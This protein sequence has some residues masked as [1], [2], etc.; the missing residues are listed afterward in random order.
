MRHARRRRRRGKIRMKRSRRKRGGR[1]GHTTVI[2]LN[3]IPHFNSFSNKT[4]F[5]N[6]IVIFCFY[7]KRGTGGEIVRTSSLKAENISSF[8]DLFPS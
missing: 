8:T 5:Y 3:Q 4:Y 6:T 7:S 1:Q 2:H